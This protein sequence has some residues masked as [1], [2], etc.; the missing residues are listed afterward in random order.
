MSNCPP[1]CNA[2]LYFM[3]HIW[4]LVTQYPCQHWL[5]PFSLILLS[6]VDLK[7][8][9]IVVFICTSLMTCEYFSYVTPFHFPNDVFWQ[10]EVFKV[11]KKFYWGKI[12]V[13]KFTSILTKIHNSVALSTFTML[14]SY[15]YCFH[16]PRQNPCTH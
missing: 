6:P 7:E 13:T 11:R 15:H 3:S 16:H 10:V 12:Y 2:N 14:Y 8:Y 9:L 5:L 1:E 4:L